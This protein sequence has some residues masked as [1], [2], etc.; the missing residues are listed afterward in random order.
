MNFFESI[1]KKETSKTPVTRKTPSVQKY[2]P[3][4][5]GDLIDVIADAL[6]EKF[7]LDNEKLLKRIKLGY[8]KAPFGGERKTKDGGWNSIS[9]ALIEVI[10]KSECVYIKVK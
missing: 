9:Y 7:E 10:L 6:Q 5:K 8:P 3:I 1:T 4:T 2:Q